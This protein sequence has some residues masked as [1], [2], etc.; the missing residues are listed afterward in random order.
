MINAVFDFEA[1]RI[2]R[3]YASA[4]YPCE[5]KGNVFYD[6]E[7][8]PNLKLAEDM[9]RSLECLHSV[10]A[11]R[12]SHILM[13]RDILGGKPLYYDSG[14]ISS[15]SSHLENPTELKPGELI[16]I[17]YEGRILERKR[18]GFEE[19]ILREE[20]NPE[21]LEKEI[22]REISCLKPRNCCIAFSG[23]LDSALLASLYD[24]PLISVTSSEKE[25]EWVRTVA[26]ELSR[27]IDVYRISEEDVSGAI[28][29]VSKAIE[30]GGFLQ[31]SIAIPVHFAMKFAKNNGFDEIMFGQGADELFGGYKRYEKYSGGDL[32]R[33]ML[34]DLKNIGERNLVR[35]C[36]LSYHN[37]IRLI[38][39]YLRWEVIRGSLSIPADLKVARFEG[40][41]VRKYFLRKIAREY[42]P[43]EVVWKEKKAIQYST[44]VAKIL[45][46]LCSSRTGRAPGS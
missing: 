14:G 28:P 37:G 9:P 5:Q 13:S 33:V 46:R 18:F 45:R 35:D 10:V 26:K 4:V 17:D 21:D 16:K 7:I 39:P 30:T 36:K 24:L 8:V 2:R 31:L 27:E 11:F 6:S 38:L 42:L 32:E 34:E 20:R 29:E 3:I 1:G 23:G 19:A 41:V 22:I 44:G 12:P 43:E 15:F 40:R 25:E